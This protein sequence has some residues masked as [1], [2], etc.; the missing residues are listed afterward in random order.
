MVGPFLLV[1]PAFQ[2]S[3]LGADIHLSDTKFDKNKYRV[4]RV[5]WFLPIIIWVIGFFGIIAY[6][7]GVLNTVLP[8]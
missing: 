3:Y 6:H 2:I 5:L 4:M 7:A 8:N 1:L